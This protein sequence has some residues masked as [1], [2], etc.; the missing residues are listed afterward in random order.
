MEKWEPEQGMVSE[1]TTL[2][3]YRRDCRKTAV[4]KALE[5]IHLDHGRY[6]AQPVYILT[7]F[8]YTLNALTIW[9][10]IWERNQWVTWT[11]KSVISKDII[12]GA[13]ELLGLLF[14]QGLRVQVTH[15]RSHAGMWGNE[16]ADE[17]ARKGALMPTGI[18]WIWDNKFD[19]NELENELMEILEFE[20]EELD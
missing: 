6:L 5:T 16:Q 11:G 7:D 9:G 2:E 18:E 12:K 8:M 4:L 20:D 17:L 13:R 14:D 1:I 19:D 15:V 3:T 10:Q